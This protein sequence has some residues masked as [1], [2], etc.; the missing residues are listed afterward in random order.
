MQFLETILTIFGR[1]DMRGQ[2]V[3]SELIDPQ[4]S[5]QPKFGRVSLSIESW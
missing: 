5:N 1:L 3:F 4:K 2:N